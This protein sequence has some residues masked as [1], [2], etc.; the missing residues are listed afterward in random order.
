MREH[1]YEK[2]RLYADLF[3]NYEKLTFISRKSKRMI[4]IEKTKENIY[5]TIELGGNGS[6]LA[7]KEIIRTANRY[8]PNNN[9]LFHTVDQQK[10]HAKHLG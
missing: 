3:I 5:M 4:I 2:N 1:S 9:V 8:N 10:Y 6:S 7:A